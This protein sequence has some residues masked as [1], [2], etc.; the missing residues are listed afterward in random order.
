M[1]EVPESLDSVTLKFQVSPRPCLRI[2][3]IAYLRRAQRVAEQR[4]AVGASGHATFPRVPR[5]RLR[6]VG[7]YCH[8]GE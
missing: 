4:A 8:R 2:R 1:P 3:H 7:G 6:I 5:D